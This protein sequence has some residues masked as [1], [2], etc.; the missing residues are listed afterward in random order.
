ME[1]KIAFAA[2]TFAFAVLFFLM[3]YVLVEVRGIRKEILLISRLINRDFLNLSTRQQKVETEIKLKLKSEE[4]FWNELG[5]LKSLLLN[6]KRREN[7]IE[8]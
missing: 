4:L 1:N 8:A 6:R 3:R 7:G 5:K 2:V